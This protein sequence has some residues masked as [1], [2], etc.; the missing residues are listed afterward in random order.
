MDTRLKMIYVFGELVNSSSQAYDITKITL[1][2]YDASGEIPISSL[3][4]DMPNN[5][6]AYANSSIPFLVRGRMGRTQ[7]TRYDLQIDTQPA[8]HTPRTDLQVVFE[9]ASEAPSSTEPAADREREGLGETRYGDWTGRS[10]K[11]LSHT[12]LWEQVQN[13]PSQARFPNGE[14][15]VECQERF[16]AEL[17]QIRADHPNA[18][19]AAVAHADPIR[20]AVAAL[21]G[22]PLDEF[23]KLMINP[24]SVT[25]FFFT[26]QGRP[27]LVRYNDTGNI[28]LRM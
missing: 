24:A 2:V 14:S 20:L 1:R 8:E 16:V 18:I 6:S 25:A 19:V 12:R 15:L 7:F 5:Y 17:Q 3:S 11:A 22:M 23:Q 4:Y 10:I 27:H 28:Q 21:L 13:T 26:P 9:C